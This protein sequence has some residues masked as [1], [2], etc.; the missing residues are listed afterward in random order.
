MNFS[1]LTYN[2]H[3]GFSSNNRDFVLHRIRDQ[4]RE[5]DVDLALLQEVQGENQWHSQRIRNWPDTS[6][7]EFLADSVWSHHAYGKNAIADG[8]H[9]GNAILSKYPFSQWGN[10]NIS[11]LSFASRSLLHGDITIPGKT[12]TIH[13][14]CLHLGL[15][16]MERRQQLRQLNAHLQ[17][18]YE[19]HKAI[20][21][22][23]DFNDWSSR[24][25]ARYLD[26]ALGLQEIFLQCH[27]RHART[28][29]S[30]WPLLCM[31]RI[32]F[33]GMEA[34]SAQCLDSREW[35]TLSDHVPL[36]ARFTLP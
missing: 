30:R 4:L 10:I 1:V 35:R 2:I 32:Y 7:F 5:L 15:L 19:D 20:V 28:F 23:G 22:A 17:S 24:Q 33:R 9:H 3:K 8:K 18:V 13:V 14:V 27:Q 31:D 34:H 6:Q 12:A 16:G 36:L 26:P 29:P 21:V 25:V 11:P